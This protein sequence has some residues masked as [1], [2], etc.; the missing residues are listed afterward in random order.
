M[1]KKIHIHLNDKFVEHLEFLEQD[2]GYSISET[3]RYLI[4][5]ETYRRKR[6]GIL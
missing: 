2:T 4:E 1:A 6:N 3:I 5:S